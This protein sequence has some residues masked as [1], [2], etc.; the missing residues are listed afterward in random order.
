MPLIFLFLLLR[1]LLARRP[2]R[3][4]LGLVLLLALALA[5]SH[6]SQAQ[7][8]VLNGPLGSGLFGTGVYMLPNGNYVVTDPSFSQGGAV[9]VGAVYLYRGSN[10][11]LIS[12]L[13]G[14]TAGDRVGILGVRI[15]T[16]G[17]YVVCSPSWNNSRG[18][19]TWGSG[20]M[21]VAGVVSA[22]NSLVGT[23]PGDV[24]SGGR[25]VVGNFYTIVP[26][27]NGNYVVSSFNWN[28]NLG[29]VTWGNGTT[30]VV[31]TISAANSLV[32][33][34]PGDQVGYGFGAGGATALPNGNYVVSTLAWNSRRG[35]ATWGNGTTGVMG[36]IS[37]GNSLVGSNPGD[38]VSAEG[39]TVL[40]NG[41]Y[42]V[43]SLGWSGHLGAVTWGNGMSG[44]VGTSPNDFVGSNGVTALVNGNYVV[45]SPN[46]NGHRGAAT[47]SNG[48]LGVVG[49]I[50]TANSLVGTSPGDLIGSVI[51]NNGATALSNGNYVVSSPNWNDDRGAA[52]WGSG[53]AGVVGTVSTA[54]S[55]VGNSPGDQIGYGFG[56]GNVTAL[57]NGNYVV[58]SPNWN[59]KRGAT[60][61]VSGAAAVVGTVSDANS[62]VGTSPGD[63]VGYGGVTALTNGNYVVRSFIW[64]GNR[65]A[66]T[67]GSGTTG[68]VGVVSTAN[69]LVGTN[70]GD[71]VGSSY[72]GSYST[73]PGNVTAL[74]N[75]NYVVGNPGWNSNRGA[76]TWGSGTTGVVGVVSAANSL[77][78]TSPNDYVGGGNSATAQMDGNYV[79]SSPLWNNGSLA[80]A[81]A[82]TLGNGASGTAGT[83]TSCNSIVGTVAYKSYTITYAYRSSTGTL[84]GGLSTLN[85]VQLGV[86]APLAPAGA[87]SQSLGAGTTVASLVATGQ[88]I[89]WY[90]TASGGSPLAPTTALI[91]GTTYYATQTV[92]GCESQTRLAVT[93]AIP[94]AAAGPVVLAE[95]VRLYPNPVGIGTPVAV[96]VPGGL[97]GAP[98]GAPLQLH[99]LNVLGQHVGHPVIASLLAS[100]TTLALPTTGLADGVYLLRLTVGSTTLIK[101]LILN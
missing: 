74:T 46:W 67:W 27:A 17:N 61:W 26:L 53:T 91:A 93:V 41:N 68:V 4:W 101:R 37:A 62:L 42:V 81:G 13:T 36:T 100:G 40:T 79:V 50:S 87:A 29:A 34:N 59:D 76:A 28:G 18:A 56:Y 30:G 54:N 22:T 6:V 60:T 65:G 23:N 57:T 63:Q 90:A 73:R 52:T 20:T 99:L 21:G 32:G 51:G 89:Q 3:A 95:Q 24:V 9:N 58:S 49:T 78:G 75:G 97:G 19:A 12:T 55:L 31:G 5:T 38:E 92:G 8:T 10:N 25:N 47:W 88:S 80:S 96:Q 86:G 66:A 94:L 48:I 11:T 82:V 43:R 16:N 15:L 84:L 70:P 45:S 35:A 2:G 7:P 77:V 98:A 39:I 33:S 14:S 83:I 64:N 69:S 71:P 1:L 44:M 72:L 85:Q